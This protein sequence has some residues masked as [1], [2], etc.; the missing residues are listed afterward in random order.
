MSKK[1]VPRVSV[2]T[3][4]LSSSSTAKILQSLSRLEARR[5]D[6]RR[7]LEELFQQKQVI[8]LAMTEIEQELV[9]L[10][11]DIDALEQE[12]LM[13]LAQQVVG[14]NATTTSTI[15]TKNGMQPSRISAVKKEATTT[16]D[17]RE[18]KGIHHFHQTTQTQADEY[19]T[20]PM[21]QLPLPTTQPH[22]HLTDPST[23]MVAAS[24]ES[25][26]SKQPPLRKY[27]DNDYEEDD[28]IVEEPIEDDE[29]RYHSHNRP[30]SRSSS[31]TV[32]PLELVTAARK[33]QQES[34]LKRPPPN[35]ATSA[36]AP[37]AYCR[38]NS[39]VTHP[40][41]ASSTNITD[42][43][44]SS[45]NFHNDT[46]SSTLVLSS[47]SVDAGVPPSTTKTTTAAAAAAHDP[48]ARFSADNFPW[49]QDVVRLLR[50]TFHIPSFRG[51]QK[52]IINATLSQD[53]VFV[54]MR[55][56]GG[57]SLTYQ[58]PALWEGRYQAARKVTFVI[59]PLISLIQ[60][61]EDQ[62]NDFAPGSAI[63]FSSGLQGGNAEHA[64]RWAMVR[65]P[66]QGVCLVFVTPEKVH[67][68][69]KL[70]NEMEKLY[71]QGRL[72]RFVVD[73][74]HCACQW[75]H[76]FRPDYAQLGILKSHFPSI[77][78]IAVTATASDKVRH[79]VCQILRLGSNY[80]FFRST[81]NRPNLR[82]SI[83]P[84]KDTKDAFVSDMV[85]YI[86]KHHPYETGI[87]YTFSKKDAD[88]VADKLCDLGVVARAY[89]SDVSPTQRDL[90]HKSWMRNET[91]VVVA[92]IAFGLG[93]NK[94]DVR[95]V[96]HHT[97]S[98]TLDAYYQESGRAGRDGKEAECVL[99]YSPK[100]RICREPR[101]EHKRAALT[102]KYV[103]LF[104]RTLLACSKWFMGRVERVYSGLWFAMRKHR[105]MMKFAERF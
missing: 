76:D 83:R 40:V 2:E 101:S 90:I 26:R 52:E 62:M 75:G 27:Q 1:N 79:D 96:L 69:K 48:N 64:R 68:S 7:R 12:N 59:S 5:E 39:L 78:L 25:E 49:S 65:D 13:A 23:Q 21:T 19:L 15:T 82:Y 4:T 31:S 28:H 63:S 95:F 45:T 77:P 67:K 73:E 92:T 46:A 37:L 55:T 89:H 57:K 22:E 103:W 11:D 102:V 41:V 38:A 16:P 20:D 35:A 72:G 8:E 9:Q 43:S 60:D 80:R 14:P 53:D 3:S 97:I 56:G 104:H 85:D 86:K 24:A 87:V 6:Q 32:G 51:H 81:A 29:F 94:P 84:K 36:Q 91:Q 42:R 99:W 54:I 47:S 93:I 71:A 33:K 88:T 66:E 30:P 34:N 74:C 98:K 44:N 61:Q 18:T 58:L 105:E 10:D 70:Q 100:V 50:D 17:E